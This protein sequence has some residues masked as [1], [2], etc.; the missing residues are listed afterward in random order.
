MDKITRS[1]TCDD[2]DTF[3]FHPK[4]VDVCARTLERPSLIPRTQKGKNISW[5][6]IST[7]HVCILAYSLRAYII[8]IYAVAMCILVVVVIFHFD[9]KVK[10]LPHNHHQ[11]HL[12]FVWT[13]HQQATWLVH[14]P[15][16]P[17]PIPVN[18]MR[19]V[20]FQMKLRR[21]M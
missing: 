18:L 16:I 19:K 3:K 2:S 1:T 20:T 21:Q 7:L 12:L 14:L 6:F 15:L 13:H 8:I 10:L 9:I 17:D 11:D 4:V 5:L